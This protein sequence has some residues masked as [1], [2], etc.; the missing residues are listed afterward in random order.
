MYIAD[1]VNHNVLKVDMSSQAISVHVHEPKMNQPNDLAIGPDGTLWA[2]DPAWSEQTGQLWR[3][4]RDG[5]VTRVASEMGTTNGIEASPDGR[6]L[7]VNESVQR[8]VWAF[9]ITAQRTLAGKRLLRKFSD[10]G[11]DGMRCDVDG[12]LWCGWGM[13]EPE[14]DGVRKNPRVRRILR[15]A[16]RTGSE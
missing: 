15:S 6:R 13:G 4:D 9:E 5:Q 3:I 2:S 1:Y 7:Y 8:N 12:N 14:L 16:G 10:F 11:F